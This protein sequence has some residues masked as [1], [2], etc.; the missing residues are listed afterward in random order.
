M[1]RGVQVFP[2]D[3]SPPAPL[4]GR[5]FLALYPDEAVKTALAAH[6]D[7]WRWPPDAA[8][9]AP[10]DWHVTLHFIGAVPQ[11]C[12]DEL[13]AG[14]ALPASPFELR[15]GQP[16]LWPHGLA[17]LRPIAVPQA[18]EQLHARLGQALRRLGWRTD[19]R[20]YRP[21]ITLAR[22]A[23]QVLVPTPWPAFG[24]PVQGYALMASTGQPG[25][26]YRVLRQYGVSA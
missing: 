19:A 7:A 21:H 8:C 9:Y 22:R 11:S 3:A 26:R 23:E 4:T 5:L 2:G 18:L 20:P 12:I 6:A 17:V 10:A 24:W 25:P 13:G 16:E 1:W 14:L 15:F